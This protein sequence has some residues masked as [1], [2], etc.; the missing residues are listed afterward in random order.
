MIEDMACCMS[1]V[2]INCDSREFLGLGASV[3]VRFIAFY[4]RNNIFDTVKNPMVSPIP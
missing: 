2:T 1:F 3:R 4:C